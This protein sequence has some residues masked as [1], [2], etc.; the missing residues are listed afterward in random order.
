MNK[1]QIDDDS[2]SPRN[3]LSRISYAKNHG[4]TAEQ[5]RAEAFDQNGR[6]SATFSRIR[7][8]SSRQQGIRLR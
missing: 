8:T 6:R 2:L 3:V 4:Q 5:L 7:K 1:L